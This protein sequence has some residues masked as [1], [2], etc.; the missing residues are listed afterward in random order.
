MKKIYSSAALE[1]VR[2]VNKDIVTTS[3]S[4]TGESQDNGD[5]LVGGRR[6]DGDD[7]YQGY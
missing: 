6:F 2:L 1:V 7:F 3:F 5:A 4:I